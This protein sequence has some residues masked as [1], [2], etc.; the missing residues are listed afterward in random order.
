MKL[1]VLDVDDTLFDW[2]TMWSESFAAVTTTLAGKTR[3]S[4]DDLLTALRRLHQAARTSE[5]GFVG[6]D[7]GALGI[8]AELAMFIAEQFEHETR[9]RTRLFPDVLATLHELRR[10]GVALVAHTDTPV[11][12]GAD[13]F[14]ELGLDG[15]VDV[16]FATAVPGAIVHRRKLKRPQLTRVV[17]VPHAKPDPRA[18]AHILAS[19]ERGPHECFYV[20]DSKM[21]DIPMARAIGAVDIFAAYGCRRDS[22]PYELLRKVSH[23]T[24]DDIARERALLAA[25]P[26][27]SLDRFSDILRFAPTS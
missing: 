9:T 4:Q 5:R 1:L 7:A 17:E 16:L 20:G 2:L 12:V 6:G 3:H 13:R 15:V 11:D 27:H 8:N 24:D 26:T 18:L 23:W 10:R 22:A 21:K 14:V 25:E 19:C